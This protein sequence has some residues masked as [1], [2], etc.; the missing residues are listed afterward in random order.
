MVDDL[1]DR[2]GHRV[3]QSAD[4]GDQDERAQRIPAKKCRRVNNR[5]VWRE[6]RGGPEAVDL[7]GPEEPA[8]DEGCCVVVVTDEVVGDSAAKVP[9]NF[10]GFPRDYLSWT[11]GLSRQRVY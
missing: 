5:E 2:R 4:R 9:G 3:Q 11:V 6:G 1:L 8:P 7:A 10:P